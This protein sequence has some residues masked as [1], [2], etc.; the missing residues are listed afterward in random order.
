MGAVKLIPAD[1]WFSKCVRMRTDWHCERCGSYSPEDRR[2]GLH[3]A[4][5]FRRG[6]WSV[7]F[8]PDNC[9][10]LCNG[11]HRLYDQDYDEQRRLFVSLRGE[12]LWEIMREKKNDLNLGRRLKREKKEIAKHY[13]EQFA[14]M[15][16]AR[17]N[18]ETGRVE[19]EA[20]A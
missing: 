12:G 10:A 14:K 3:C 2:M 9:L 1:T 16:E 19:F 18:G 4:H 15:Q 7:R 6:N 11:C 20:Y 17:N 13:R 5:T 8:D